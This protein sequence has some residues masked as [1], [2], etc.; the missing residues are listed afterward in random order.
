MVQSAGPE[1]EYTQ[2]P[3]PR[4]PEDASKKPKADFELKIHEN[5]LNKHH[6][7][8]LA[9]G[10]D[11]TINEPTSNSDQDVDYTF[12]DAGAQWRMTKLK[13][14]YRRAK[15]ER[16]QIDDVAVSLYGDLRI[17]DDARE[18]EIEL[19]RRETYGKEYSGKE[20]PD[21]ELFRARKPDMKTGTQIPGPNGLMEDGEQSIE[22]LDT[23]S[24]PVATVHMDQTALNRLKAQ[25]M[26]A[27][28]R[29]APDA[30]ALEAK[31]NAAVAEY[32]SG[33]QSGEVVLGAMENRMLAG[34]RK[35]EVKAVDNRRGRERGLVEEN[36]DM[37]ISDM[38]KEE[39]RTRGQVGGEGRRFAE[40]IAKDGKFDVTKIDP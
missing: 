11:S 12:G 32:A 8:N 10:V 28:F 34:G 4:S 24:P 36:E 16:R 29:R 39:R 18:E 5:E 2:R 15:E 37:S 20:K 26:K 7:Q 38:V 30:A 27:K 14:V 3:A 35:G 23:E 31:Y 25:M 22:E 1:I 6:L 21:G 13:G 17:F 9:E 19:G 33:K 40:R